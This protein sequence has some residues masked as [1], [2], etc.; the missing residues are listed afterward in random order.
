MSFLRMGRPKFSGALREEVLQKTNGRCKHC[1]AALVGNDW[2][3]DHFPVVYRD[4]EDQCYCWP[5]GTVVDPLDLSN[6][7]PSCCKCNRSHKHERKV[8]LFCGRT[9]LR[10]RRLWLKVF[11]VL[12]LGLFVGFMLGRF[13]PS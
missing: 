3:V 12:M 7:Q 2:D 11:G 5:C 9:Q 6:L 8:W 10:I 13:L 4:I 1:N